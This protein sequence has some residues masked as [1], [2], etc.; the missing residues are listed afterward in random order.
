[1]RKSK[2]EKEKEREDA[3]KKEEEELAAK[4]YAEF[5]DAFDGQEASKRGSFVKAS[6]SNAGGESYNPLSERRGGSWRDDTREVRMVRLATCRS[7]L[8]ICN[9]SVF[10]DSD[11]QVA[12][13][14]TSSEA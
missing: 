7:S 2:R 14:R 5:L 12:S 3:K 1:M 11:V 8:C 4:T 9:S 13:D 10:Y 6:G